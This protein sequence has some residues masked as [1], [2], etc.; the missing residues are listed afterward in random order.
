MLKHLYIENYALIEKLDTDFSA[1]FSVITG[2]TGAGKS[3]LLGA[4][5]LILG[6]RADTQVLLDTSKRCIVEGSFDI[7]ELGLQDIF[8]QNDL[9]YDDTVIFRREINQ[10]GKSRAFVN[11]TPV[12][13]TVLKD[14][15]E[16]LVD[17][18]SQHQTLVLAE[19]NF[20]VKVI[21]SYAGLL[22]DVAEFSGLYNDYRI[23]TRQLEKLLSTEAQAKADLDYLRFQFDELEKA[24]LIPDEQKAFE[25]ELEVMNHTEEIKLGLNK[26][27]YLF[28]E[29]ENNTLSQILEANKLLQQLSR[30]RNDINSISERTNSSYLELK[31][32]VAELDNIEQQI[33]FDP[34]RLEYIKA[35]LNTIY[36]LQ[37]KHR[38]LTVKELIEVIDS[39]E[40]KIS[41][42]SSLDD[43]IIV[44]RT[45]VGK[46]ESVLWEKARSVS[47]KRH[48][49]VTGIEKS[50]KESHSLLGMPNGTFSVK[51][52]DRDSLTSTGNN[53]ITFLFNAN[54]GGEMKEIGKIAS[55]GELSRL[56]L[57]VKS[58]IS[59]KNLLPTVIFDEI[60][61]GVSGDVANKVAGIMKKMAKTMQVIAITHLPQIAAKGDTHFFVYKESGKTSTKSNIRQLSKEERII[62]IAKLL[63]G[64]SPS[65]AA[66]E[67]AKELL[68]DNLDNK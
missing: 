32:I 51:I 50:I 42:I 1:G 4:L 34:E 48:K 11:D 44:L 37:Q 8:K 13:L 19:K 7:K 6:Q 28:R 18:H 64:D 16:R 30:Y 56:M 47:A 12:N 27:I 53:E 24:L 66:I 17:I 5:S 60:D 29:V 25:N 3:I 57:A 26:A 15:A 14:I 46:L 59:E 35:R 58:L 23:K 68:K 41:N 22:H 61:I 2:E 63:S 62:E 40:L 55:G 65:T 10:Q 21:D 43:Q 36:H 52:T 54:K 45:E 9:D 49:S 31:D 38:V 20:Q 33:V 67:N 39:L